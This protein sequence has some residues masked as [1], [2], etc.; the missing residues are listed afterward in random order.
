MWVSERL[1]IRLASE[2]SQKQQW[3]IWSETEKEIIA[4]GEVENAQQLKK[5]SEKAS[6]RQVICL[7]PGVDVAIKEVVIKGAFNR[8][9]QQALPYLMEEDLAG[10]V[11]KLHFTVIEKRTDLVH[12]AVCD[13]QRMINWLAWLESAEIHC[14]QFIPEG[15]A[16]PVPEDETWQALQLDNEWIIRESEALAWSCEVSMLALVLASK[17]APENHQK[18]ANYST[19]E[20]VEHVEWLNALPVLPMELLTRGAINNKVN[21]LSGE[22]KVHKEVNQDL[23]KWRLPAIFGLLFF[24]LSCLNIV[25]ENRHIASQIETTKAHV[26]KIY[27][28]AFPERSELSYTRIKRSMTSMLNEIGTDNRDNHFLGM[29]N[30]VAPGFKHNKT[31]TPR[32]LKYDAAKQEMRILSIGENFQSFEQFAETLPTQYKLQQGALNSSKNQVSGLLTIRKE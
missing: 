31:L 16:L 28:L 4:S 24:L 3:L 19:S 9:M 10:D 17:I 29:L 32:T 5:L 6:S 30:D 7:V 23:L 25:I 13:K 15:L 27:Q 2:A 14:L 21:L 1:I 12:V 20:E 11:E 8:Q 22:F 26:E 18:I